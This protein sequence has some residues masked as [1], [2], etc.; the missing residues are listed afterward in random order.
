MDT[1]SDSEFC[2]ASQDF[3]GPSSL[4]SAFSLQLDQDPNLE[5]TLAKHEGALTDLRKKLDEIDHKIHCQTDDAF[6]LCFLRHKK[7]DVDAA[8]VSVQK[9]YKLRKEF[10]EKIWPRGKGV[11]WMEDYA[12]LNN[13]TVFP[14]RNAI[15]GSWVFAWRK[16][17]WIPEEEKYVLA[18]Y[19]TW[20]LYLAEYFLYKKAKL[21]ADEGWTLIMDLSGFEARHIP[22]CDLRV[23]RAYTSI[24]KG[25]L[26]VKIK[27]I[28]FVNVPSVFHYVLVLIKFLLTDKLRSRFFVHKCVV[29]LSKTIDA[30]CLPEEYGGS[31]TKFSSRWLFDEMVQYEQE[32]V[33]RSYFGYR[34]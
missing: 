32:F 23:V 17:D 4:D 24:L 6:L 5:M 29:D 16:G 28:H 27:A 31:G 30:E 13:C 25:A 15:D 2:D 14:I 33:E 7:F 12:A 26:P 9:Y 10:P 19:L 18:D 34:Q 8:F 21:N 1:L 22:Y 11:K 3:N 20:G